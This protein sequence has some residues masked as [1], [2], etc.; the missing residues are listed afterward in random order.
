M[1]TTI[2]TVQGSARSELAP[3]Q[4]V[5]RFT[6]A[7]DG[8]ERAPVVTA[9]MSALDEV[10]AV[11]EA[12]HDAA[13][14]PVSRWSA[15]RVLISS[16]RPWTNDGTPA[17]LVH[18]ASVSGRATVSDV[19]AVGALAEELAAR[20]LVT[21]DSL[22]WSLTDAR[23]ELE[24]RDVLTRAASDARAK[25]DVLA[26]AAGLGSLAPLAL[27]DPGM[28]DG[29]APGPGPMPRIERAMAMSADQQGGGGF[30]LRPEPIVLEVAVDARFSAQ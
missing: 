22:E 12:L 13:A 5:L 2:I 4:A 14:G 19:D 20:V 16:H 27:A 7:S 26:A 11:I 8:P 9:V 23:L 29:S 3:E 17:P 28:L 10:S 30:S 6:I 18:Q 15:D 21:I 24:R 25:A 1:S